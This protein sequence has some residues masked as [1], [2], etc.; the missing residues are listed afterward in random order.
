MSEPASGANAASKQ[1]TTCRRERHDSDATAA[2]KVE[3]NIP[4]PQL[5]KEKTAAEAQWEERTAGCHIGIVQGVGYALAKN[6]AGEKNRRV[7]DLFEEVKLRASGNRK[8]PLRVVHE[9]EHFAEKVVG[10]I[11]DTMVTGGVLTERA[12]GISKMQQYLGRTLLFGPRCTAAD[13]A[14]G[15]RSYYVAVKK[16]A[17]TCFAY[18]INN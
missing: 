6:D 14:Q 11:C 9:K 12:G 3:M 5:K 17:L 7:P 2:A 13:T 16:T 8:W 10:V 18:H 4:D 15:H 1:M